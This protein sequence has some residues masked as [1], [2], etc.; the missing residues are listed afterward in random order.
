MPLQEIEVDY[1]KV[2]YLLEV[3][4]EEDVNQCNSLGRTPLPRNAQ[5]TDY[6][7]C[8][9]VLYLMKRL[10]EKGTDEAIH[11]NGGSTPFRV[12]LQKEDSEELVMFYYYYYSAR[13]L[14]NPGTSDQQDE[15]SNWW[16]YD[17]DIEQR[18]TLRTFANQTTLST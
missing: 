7:E 4:S 1:F 9:G 17:P 18:P 2:I 12:F 6:A 13:H 16:D 10:L 14:L 11:D 3:A 5:G 8:H 15:Y